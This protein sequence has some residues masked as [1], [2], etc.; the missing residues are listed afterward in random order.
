MRLPICSAMDPLPCSVTCASAR[1]SASVL[2]CRKSDPHVFLARQVRDVLL[3]QVRL[4][5]SAA[6]CRQHLPL[7]AYRRRGSAAAAGL[8]RCP[9]YLCSSSCSRHQLSCH[10]FA[11]P[12][13]RSAS[14]RP[15]TR[16]H[17]TCIPATSR[18]TACPRIT[19]RPASRYHVPCRHASYHPAASSLIRPSACLLDRCS[20]VDVGT[21]KQ[22]LLDMPSLGQATPRSRPQS[23]EL[24]A[25]PPQVVT[26]LED[27]EVTQSN[28]QS[29]WT[30]SLQLLE[31]TTPLRY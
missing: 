9:Q 15:A 16:H 2:H 24:H 25:H 26:A 23:D 20:Q 7:Q 17:V 13:C 6:T 22:T 5:L 3:H 11:L 29:P 12:R 1:R 4:Q 27:A 31:A 14:S 30:V 18:P 19:S 21:L 8:Q 28:A 10:P